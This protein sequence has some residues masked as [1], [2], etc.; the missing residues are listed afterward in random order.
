MKKSK[1]KTI[2]KG[3]EIPVNPGADIILP[4]PPEVLDA[5]KLQIEGAS[6]EDLK[7]E[8][9]KLTQ[10]IEQVK[11]DISI[12]KDNLTSNFVTILGIFASIVTFLLI[13]IQILKNIC[14]YWRLIGFS[15]FILGGLLSFIGL[16]HYVITPD[17]NESYKLKSSLSVITLVIIIFAIFVFSM[18]KASDEYSCKVTNLNDQFEILKTQLEKRELNNYFDLDRRLKLLEGAKK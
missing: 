7:E 1:F 15:A 6:K 17:P 8:V 12:T 11:T 13:E 9:S 5:K 10:K 18:K 16:L 2:I 3:S 14:D 4:I